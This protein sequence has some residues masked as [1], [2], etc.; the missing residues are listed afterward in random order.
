M[1]IENLLDSAR[2]GFAGVDVTPAVQEDALTSLQ[3]WLSDPYFHSYQAQ[4]IALIEAGRWRPLID[5]FYRTC[6]LYTSPSPRD[7]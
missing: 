4:I 6:L 1:D 7:S 3:S 5:S 2:V